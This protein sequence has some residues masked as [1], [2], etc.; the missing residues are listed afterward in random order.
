MPSQVLLLQIPGGFWQR[1]AGSGADQAATPL[2]SDH[3]TLWLRGSAGDGAQQRSAAGGGY[4]S[5]YPPHSHNV[6]APSVDGEPANVGKQ[7][8][9]STA[10]DDEWAQAHP[11]KRSRTASMLRGSQSGRTGGLAHA[12]GEGR[13]VDGQGL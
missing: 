9:G 5:I 2:A 8:S 12:P 1:R 7:F 10:G 4:G 3:M 6:A 13:C 11:A